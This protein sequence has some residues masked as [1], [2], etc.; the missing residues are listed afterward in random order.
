MLRITEKTEDERVI[1]LRL[2]GTITEKSYAELENALSRH[3]GSN[4]RRIVL[5]MSGVVF[6]QDSVAR[7]LGRLRGES[8]QIVNDSPFIAALLAAAT[9]GKP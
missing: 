2:D 9:S 1:R 6:M 4:G 5:D 7:K 8:L 3:R